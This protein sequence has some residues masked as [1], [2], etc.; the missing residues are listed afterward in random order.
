[1]EGKGHAAFDK[2]SRLLEK[3]D[4]TRSIAYLERAIAQYPEHYIAYYDLGVAHLRL[5]QLEEA[6]QSFQKSIDLTKGNFAP[7]QFGLAAVL[8]QERQ[9]SPAE[10]ILQRATN[11]DPGSAVGKY[12]LAWAQLGLNRPVEAERNLEQAL[13]RNPKLAEAY[14]LLAR[15]HLRERNWP[16]ATKDLESYLRIEPPNQRVKHLADLI[17]Q[18]RT[19]DTAAAA[20]ARPGLQGPSNTNLME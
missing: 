18:Q 3:G 11:L 17:Q 7:A 13:L 15:V 19:L 4:T 9:F 20:T 14:L 16:G 5:S 6:E 10:S 1:M 2:G 8:C 12:Y